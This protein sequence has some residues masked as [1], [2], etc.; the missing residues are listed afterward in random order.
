MKDILDSMIDDINKLDCLLAI[1]KEDKKVNYISKKE[2]KEWI[3]KFNEVRKDEI[4]NRTVGVIVESI[5]NDL[6]KQ[7]DL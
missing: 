2:L 4:C 1:E 5:F 3:K 7:F 6:I